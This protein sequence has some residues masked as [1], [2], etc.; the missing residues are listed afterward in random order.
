[1]VH[2]N[3]L[4]RLVGV[5]VLTGTLGCGKATSPNPNAGKEPQG[6]DG[7]PR[8]KNGSDKGTKER[9]RHDPSAV[10][11]TAEELAKEWAASRSAT[12]QKY[13]GKRIEVRGVVFEATSDNVSEQ[14]QVLLYS[15]RDREKGVTNPIDCLFPSREE[16]RIHSLAQ[17]QTV[18]IRGTLSDV[19]HGVPLVDCELV[20]AG[21]S[22]AINLTARQLVSD[23]ITDTEEAGKKYNQKPVVVEG[24][25]A[26][27]SVREDG[28][29]ILLQGLPKKETKVVV[30][31]ACR[32]NKKMR[33]QLSALARGQAV[34]VRG[35]CGVSEF[36]VEPVV[37]DAV[38]LK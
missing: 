32:Y 12:R 36:H 21:A 17:G 20:G 28:Y 10:A 27:V 4:A 34:T 2:W 11:V 37:E 24:V 29:R 31:C 26:E 5:L 19:G 1:M 7:T 35:R 30:N 16:K 38:L 15:H 25:V 18:T 14:P 33:K 23:F 6:K 22:P 8:D 9:P 3:A 13:K